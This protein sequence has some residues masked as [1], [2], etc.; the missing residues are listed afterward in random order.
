MSKHCLHQE[1]LAVTYNLTSINIGSAHRNDNLVER[2]YD[3]YISVRDGKIQRGWTLD[4]NTF[5]E[6]LS[7]RFQT[8]V[9]RSIGPHLKISK[10][11]RGLRIP[12]ILKWNVPEYRYNYISIIKNDRKI[13]SVSIQVCK[14][15]T[16]TK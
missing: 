2:W 4:L 6:S 5:F 14:V 8:H 16:I 15:A 13:L 10:L 11:R 7:P 12:P 9:S 3:N 1:L